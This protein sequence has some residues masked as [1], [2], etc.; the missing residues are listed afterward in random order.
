MERAC[1]SPGNIPLRK[2]CRRSKLQK[3]RK[4]NKRKYQDTVKQGTVNSEAKGIE[5]NKRLKLLKA[6]SQGNVFCDSWYFS[7]D[8]RGT[9]SLTKVLT[10]FKQEN[11]NWQWVGIYLK[12][13]TVENGSK[14][15][16]GWKHW[17]SKFCSGCMIDRIRFINFFS[18]YLIFSWALSVPVPDVSVKVSLV[19]R[20]KKL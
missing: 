4:K 11:C 7:I 5:K 1:W 8:W 13:Y 2:K 16:E 18:H 10:Q 20:N 17:N 19:D 6:K 3:Q 15:K 14:T 12:P 9:S